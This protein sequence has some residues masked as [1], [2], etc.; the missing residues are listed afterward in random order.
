MVMTEDYWD[1][2]PCNLVVLL[3]Y[4]GN[5]L[6]PSSVKK[7]KPN[8]EKSL[9]IGTGDQDQGCGQTN[10]GQWQINRCTKGSCKRRGKMLEE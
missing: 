2:M 6:P 3:K 9:H 1:V 8:V 4:W 5:V 10:G 7:W